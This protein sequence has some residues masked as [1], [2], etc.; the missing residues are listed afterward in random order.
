[1]RLYNCTV[2]NS[3]VSILYLHNMRVVEHRRTVVDSGHSKHSELLLLL[4]HLK[5]E[6]CPITISHL[7]VVS[8]VPAWSS[9]ATVMQFIIWFFHLQILLIE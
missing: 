3:L 4:L 2:L 9:S 7:L 8:Q 1:V 5:Y 6:Q